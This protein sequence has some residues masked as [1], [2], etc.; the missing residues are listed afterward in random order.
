MARRATYLDNVQSENGDTPTLLLGGPF[1]FVRNPRDGLHPAQADVLVRALEAM[2]YD[3]G[4]LTEF[5]AELIEDAGFAPPEGWVVL[6]RGRIVSLDTA[7]GHRVAVVLFPE[8]D[9]N[10]TA[11]PKALARTVDNLIQEAREGHDLVVAV[12]PWGMWAEKSYL[13]TT[14]AG[15][16]ILLGAGM[17]MEIQGALTADARVLWV[18]AYGKGRSVNRVDLLAWPEADGWTWTMDKTIRAEFGTLR[19][20]VPEDPEV[21][22]ILSGTPGG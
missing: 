14:K 13:Q 19:E 4:C 12:S 1:E 18:R 7:D 22:R 6:D 11:P 3:F 20:T 5:E 17:G 10:A 9:K 21:L 16:D 15:P 8:L 2:N